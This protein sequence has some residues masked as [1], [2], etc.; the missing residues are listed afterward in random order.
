MSETDPSQDPDREIRTLLRD[1]LGVRGRDLSQQRRRA[2]RRLPR[3][4]R[5]ALDRLAQAEATRDHPKLS[6]QSDPTA[7]SRDRSEVTRHLRGVDRADR[8][9][10]A[11]L[12]FLGAL[13]FNLLLLAGLVLA[14]LRWQGFV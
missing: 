8:R 9:K 2:G 13:S 7:L 10:G 11:V 1:R 12:G 3:A 4:V 14:L 5:Q 6:R